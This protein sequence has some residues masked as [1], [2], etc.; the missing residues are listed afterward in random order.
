MEYLVNKIK[1]S[2]K[3]TVLT[4]A[5]VSTA[6]GIPDFRSSGGFWDSEIPREQYISRDYF[7]YK[8][9][10]FWLKYKDIFGI[11]LENNFLPNEVHD[12]LKWLEDEGKE[13]SVA[14]QNVDGLHVAVGSSKVYEMHG[15]ISSATCVKCGTKYGYNKILD[16]L[17]PRCDKVNKKGKLCN[18]ILKPDVVLFGDL[19]HHYND[20]L[21]ELNE[22]D[23]FIVMG[24]SLAVYPVNNLVNYVNMM[25][26]CTSIFLNGESTEK[27][28]LFDYVKLGDLVSLIREIKNEYVK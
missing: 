11:K 6:S 24:T 2:K 14:T 8:P 28:S 4:G 18:F 25:S 1:N 16:E 27:D 15:T 21:D 22:S 26:N 10:D 19:I 17:V 9:K 23:L 3:I 7:N 12:F 20:V 13:V 5:G